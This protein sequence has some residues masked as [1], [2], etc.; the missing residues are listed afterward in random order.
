ISVLLAGLG[1]AFAMA[2]DPPIDL[3]S[4]ERLRVTFDHKGCEVVI[5]RPTKVKY[6][7][8]A[9]AVRLLLSSIEGIRREFCRYPWLQLR[10]LTARLG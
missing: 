2:M 1:A 7:R 5:K 10:R 6:K 3:T 9:V 8:Q 4:R